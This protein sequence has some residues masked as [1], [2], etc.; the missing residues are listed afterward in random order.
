MLLPCDHIFCSSCIP[1]SNLFGLDCPLCKITYVEQDLRQAPFVENVVNIYRSMN[2]SISM[3]MLNSDAGRD[4]VQ[5][6]FPAKSKLSNQ[7]ARRLADS[8]PPM[9]S[10]SGTNGIVEQYEAVDV[11]MELTPDSPPSSGVSKDLDVDSRDPGSSYNTA[12]KCPSKKSV[13]RTTDDFGV[14]GFDR[15]D[16]L[17]CKKQKQH[18]QGLPDICHGST[19]SVVVNVQHSASTGSDTTNTGNNSRNLQVVEFDSASL[20]NFVCA[21]CQTWKTT[22]GSGPMQHFANG[23]QVFGSEASRP[24]VMHV[25]QSCIDWAPQIYYENDNTMKNLDKELARAGKLKC[26]SCGLK[27]AALGCYAKSCRRSYHVPCAYEIEGCRWEM[28]EFLMLCPAHASQKFPSEK[29]KK[30]AVK[31]C[32]SAQI[33]T[34]QKSAYD[35]DFWATSPT[36]P[37]DWVLCGSALSADEKYKLVR[38]ANLCGATVTKAWNSDVTHVIAATDANGACSRTLKVLMAILS[39]RWILNIDWIE[40]CMLSKCP[41]D[42]SPYE[43][44]LDNHGCSDGPKTGRLRVLNDAPKLFSSLKFFFISGFVAT[45]KNDLQNLIVAA[46]GTILES[47]EQLQHSTDEECLPSTTVLVYN[48]DLTGEVNEQRQLEVEKLA[49]ESGSQVIAHTWIL[50]SIASGVMQPFVQR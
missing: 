37:K 23:R 8:S 7:S 34:E 35:I 17:Y 27:G 10:T 4:S 13:K 39:G 6:P 14:Q 15:S 28:D 22:E 19:T 3:H 50:D 44:M 38:F 45:Y 21:F 24:H 26:T 41:V 47:A 25:H 33:Y 40:A 42:E 11:D 30:P 2:A 46:G 31:K 16:N 48:D 36:G 5:C 18:S 29:S 49:S 12:G 9:N 20:L 1:K 43:I 32:S